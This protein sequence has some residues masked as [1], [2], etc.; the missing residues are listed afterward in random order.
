MSEFNSLLI[1]IS[2][3]IIRTELE[4]MKYFCEAYKIGAKRLEEITEAYQ[5]FRELKKRDLL[6]PEKTDVLVMLLEKAGRIDL[7]NQLLGIQGICS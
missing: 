6:G 7:K 2:K 4:T 1:D 5:L 3:E